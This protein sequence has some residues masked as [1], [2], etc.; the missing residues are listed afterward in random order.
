MHL[1]IWSVILLLC[2]TST[3]W[4]KHWRV[5]LAVVVLVALA[6]LLPDDLRPR[7]AAPC[8]YACK[9]MRATDGKPFGDPNSDE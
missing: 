8:D 9:V 6:Q 4:A 7:A 2:I 3:I 1:I 5:L